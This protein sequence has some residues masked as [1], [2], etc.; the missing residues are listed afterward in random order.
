[1]VN[2][3]GLGKPVNIDQGI[4]AV[5]TIGQLWLTIVKLVLEGFE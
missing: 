5:Q 2:I 1:M 3:G 4:G